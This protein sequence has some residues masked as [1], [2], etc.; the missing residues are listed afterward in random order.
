M[1]LC[2]RSE[3]I[4]QSS[5]K[6]VNDYLIAHKRPAESPENDIRPAGSP[7]SE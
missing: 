1:R 3:V 7:L 2:P 6:D 5:F 4:D